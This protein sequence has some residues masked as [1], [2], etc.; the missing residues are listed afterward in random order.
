M[1]KYARTEFEITPNA[2]QD[3][4]KQVW[5]LMKEE[6]ED[7]KCLNHIVIAMGKDLGKA[8]IYPTL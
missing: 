6:R 5:N 1:N 7:Y 4:L 3:A 2:V 8:I